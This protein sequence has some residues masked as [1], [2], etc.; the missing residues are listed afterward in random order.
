MRKGNLLHSYNKGQA[1]F[2]AYLA[3]YAYMIEGLLAFIVPPQTK[4]G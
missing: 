1:R 4:N 2:N 3:D